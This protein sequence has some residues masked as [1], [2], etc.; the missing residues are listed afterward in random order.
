MERISKVLVIADEE[1]CMIYR[2]VGCDYIAVRNPD[3]LLNA[4]KASLSR[5]DVEVILL[6]QE[7]GEPVR[8]DV[9]KIISET[10]KVISYVPSPRSPG[11]PV[12]MRGL[13][14]RALGMG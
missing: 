5:E 7:L 9:E 13:L 2:I 6:S 3:E 14:L 11:A 8:E 1:T 10:G 12:D 4:L